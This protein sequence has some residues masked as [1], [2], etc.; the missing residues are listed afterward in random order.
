[1]KKYIITPAIALAAP[2]FGTGMANASTDSYL[3]VQV[4]AEN[5]LG[6]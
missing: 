1:M 2:L 5:Q 4:A 3:A 6:C